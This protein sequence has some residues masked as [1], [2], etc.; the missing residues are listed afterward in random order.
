MGNKKL[1]IFICVA[2]IFLLAHACIANDKADDNNPID[3]DIDVKVNITDIKE[4]SSK[5]KN[6][7]NRTKSIKDINNEKSTI[8]SAGLN[9]LLISYLRENDAWPNEYAELLYWAKKKENLQESVNVC[10]KHV[11]ILTWD[12]YENTTLRIKYIW[13]WKDKEIPGEMELNKK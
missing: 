3:M 11:K 8:S 12:I 13:K 1:K 6:D 4:E 10:E 9:D 5:E 7:E 2:L